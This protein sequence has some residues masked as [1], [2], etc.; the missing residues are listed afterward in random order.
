MT[1]EDTVTSDNIN[2]ERIV[3][4]EIILLLDYHYITL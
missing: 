4:K 1:T 2:S 3:I